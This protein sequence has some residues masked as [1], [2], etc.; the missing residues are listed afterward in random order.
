[1]TP[2]MVMKGVTFGAGFGFFGDPVISRGYAWLNRNYPE[3]RKW[4]QLR[5]YVFV[6]HILLLAFMLIYFKYYP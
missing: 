3:W 4:L 6:F 1:M 5:K 2:Y